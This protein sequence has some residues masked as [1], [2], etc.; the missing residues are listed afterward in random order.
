[1]I[2]RLPENDFLLTM[3][4]AQSTSVV[5]VIFALSMEVSLL[6]FSTKGILKVVFRYRTNR[7]RASQWIFVAQLEKRDK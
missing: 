7:M 1:M 2:T 5:M 4:C 6:S 3:S